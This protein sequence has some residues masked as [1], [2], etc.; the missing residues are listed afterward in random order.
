MGIGF[1]TVTGECDMARQFCLTLLSGMI[2]IL[3]R[4]VKDEKPNRFIFN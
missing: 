3:R 2:K 4:D 1:S